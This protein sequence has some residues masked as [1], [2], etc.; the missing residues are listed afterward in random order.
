MRSRWS[1]SPTT[2]TSIAVL[3]HLSYAVLRHLC[4]AICQPHD[5][6]I[7]RSLFKDPVATSHLHRLDAQQQKLAL[8]VLEV[9]ERVSVVV[10]S[11]QVCVW[12]GRGGGGRVC[13]GT[14]HAH[15]RSRAHALTHTFSLSHT[16][17]T[18][19]VRERAHHVW[20]REYANAAHDAGRLQS[21]DPL[22]ARGAWSRQVHGR[23]RRSFISL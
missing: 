4:S 17:H 7:Y 16:T 8:Q 3:R 15:T 18:L 14:S 22:C 20:E 9:G 11:K 19:C 21:R 10:Q 5:E 6:N 12:G 23:P 2:N 1:V 13:D